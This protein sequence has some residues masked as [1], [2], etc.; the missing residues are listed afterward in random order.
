MIKHQTI[1]NINGTLSVY[2][3]V[4]CHLKKREVYE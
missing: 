3:V 1:R 2:T 4:T